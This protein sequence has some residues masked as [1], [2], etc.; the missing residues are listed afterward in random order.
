MFSTPTDSPKNFDLVQ[1]WALNEIFLLKFSAYNPE[2]GERKEQVS[3][4][5][6]AFIVV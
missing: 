5:C 1:I 4:I 3:V 2:T 6:H